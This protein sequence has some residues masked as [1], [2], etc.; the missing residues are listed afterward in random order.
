V[1]KNSA[2]GT[3]EDNL[4]QTVTGGRTA[5]SCCLLV[6]ASSTKGTLGDNGRTALNSH[7]RVNIARG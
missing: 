3:L 5:L 1:H 6:H 4:G 2:D 7:H